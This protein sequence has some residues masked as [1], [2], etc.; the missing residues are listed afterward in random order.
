MGLKEMQEL[1]GYNPAGTIRPQIE[2]ANIRKEVAECLKEQS[3][4]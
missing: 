2:I 1:L 3:T 4:E